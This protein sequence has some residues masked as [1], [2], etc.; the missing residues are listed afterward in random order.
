MT[1]VTIR[2][3]RRWP[4]RGGWDRVRL[5][6]QPAGPGVFP[7]PLADRSPVGNLARQAPRT[8]IHI[9]W[10]QHH[11]QPNG[12]DPGGRQLHSHDFRRRWGLYHGWGSSG[13]YGDDTLLLYVFV[14]V[15]C[16][17]RSQLW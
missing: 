4:F 2:D 6:W 8:E 5:L 9:Q 14:N 15:S 12:R 17:H 11:F 13:S 16:H 1:N 7:A 3:S 10:Y